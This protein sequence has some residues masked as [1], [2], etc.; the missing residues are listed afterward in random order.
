MPW[1]VFAAGAFVY[2][3][4]VAH[5]ASFGVAGLAAVERFGVQAAMLSL[6]VVV[7]L[8]TYSLL[9]IP[10]GVALDRWG[11]GLLL[12]FGATV[13]AVSQ[14]GMAFTS[15]V[16][17]ALAL[18]LLLGLGDA[19]VF[20]SAVRL[21]WGWFERR[22]VPVL[23]QV[24]GLVG[25]LGQIITAIPF[26]FGLTHYGWQV[27]FIGLAALGLLSA[28][29]AIVWVRPGPYD[30]PGLRLSG[31]PGGL[32]ATLTSPGTWLGFFAHL[33]GGVS[34]NV[35]I[36]LWGV[37]FLVQ[38]HGLTHGQAGVLLTINVL[39]TIV[40]APVIGVLTSRHPLRRTWL[41]LGISG[42]TLTGWV[43]VLLPREPLPFS[44]LAVFVGLISIGG[45]ASLIGLD[46]AAGFNPPAWRGTAQGVANMGGFISAVVVMLGVGLMLDA[47]ASLGNPTLADYRLALSLV[48]VPIAI[49]IAG[50]LI[51]RG[52]ARRRAGIVVPT[53]AEL[54]ARHRAREQAQVK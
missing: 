34:S 25:R 44:T 6:F 2:V 50:I 41:V 15:S 39:V 5:R 23:T 48:L 26:A 13:M 19:A 10:M 11:A 20:I 32:G 24:T 14:L 54:V 43:L 27:A 53:M 17:G 8:A 21:V 7:Q 3:V 22:L 18:R 47:R 45:P 46:L 49:G 9:Q 51:T 42:L 28:A 1:L 31:R 38:G 33:L 52:P 12:T 37:P 35:F 40:A 4:A 16:G 30:S 36:L 29:I